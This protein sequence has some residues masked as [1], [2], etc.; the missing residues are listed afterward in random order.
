MSSS[1]KPSAPAEDWQASETFR[2]LVDSVNDYAIFMLDPQGYVQTW[3]AGA[4]RIKQYRAAEIIGK[5]F[6]IFYPEDEVSSGK[7]E[8]ELA[9]AAEV[10]RFEDEGWRL[11]KDGSRFWANVVITAV[12]AP[13]RGLCGFA[14]VTRD[15]TERRQAEERVRQSELRLR[16]LIENIQDYAIFMLDPAGIVTTWNRGAEAITKYSEKEIVGR[17]FSAFYPPEEAHSGHPARELQI[18]AAEG[19]YEE[20]GWRIR[21]DGSA[22]WANVVL[23][24]I[25]DDQHQLLGFAKVTRDLTERCEAQTQV[26]ARRAAEEASQAKDEFL[27]MLGHELRNP[28]APTVTALQLLRLRGDGQVSR[29]HQ[30]IERQV[31][32]MV[33]LVEDLLDVSRVSR[34]TLTLKKERVDLRGLL[35]QAVEIA[36]P[37][38]DE[39]RHNLD[40]DVPFGEI[41]LMADGVRVTQI[42]ANILTNA[43]KYTDPGG[44]IQVSVRLDRREVITEIRD[45]GVGISADLLPRVF[46]RFVQAPQARARS[47]G[48]MGIGLSLV[49]SLV[50]LHG[51]SVEAHSAG[52]GQGSTLIVKLPVLESQRRDAFREDSGRLYLEPSP[53]A[54]RVLLVDDNEDA[55]VL[56]ADVLRIAGHEVRTAGSGSAALALLGDFVPDVAVLDVGLPGMDGY[57]LGKRLRTTL[58]ARAPQLIAMTGYGQDADREQSLHAGFA[59]HLVKPVDADTLIHCIEQVDGDRHPRT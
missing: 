34:G 6:S 14:K 1:P 48:G 22:F 59:H 16:L 33:R 56:A 5:H 55:A 27:A 10:G 50:H 42:F 32:H 15:L 12:R 51:G 41:T 30:V 36:S 21:K 24:A 46:D 37:L 23:T 4:A 44:H 54:R 17:H 18:A 2:L 45:D 25:R 31:N 57:E 3:N 28:L 43:A 53:S 19:R 11:R 20:E 35:A 7:C 9:V 47:A 39:R 13:G 40:L 58:G 52:L 26:A 49:R 38:I 8:H 29:E